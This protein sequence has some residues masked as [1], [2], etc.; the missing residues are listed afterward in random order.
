MVKNISVLSLLGDQTSPGD[1]TSQQAAIAEREQCYRAILETTTDMLG[2]LVYRPD[3]TLIDCNQVFLD[4]IGY[5]EDDLKQLNL[6]DIIPHKYGQCVTGDLQALQQKGRY[7]PYEEEY[8]DKHGRAV[9]VRLN[10]VWIQH[11]GGQD[12]IFAS[13]LDLSKY[14]EQQKLQS[15]LA[16]INQAVDNAFDAF[17][18]VN[19]R[20]EFIY[21]NKSHAKLWGY[22]SVD[23]VI[24][25]SPASHCADPRIAQHIIEQTIEQSYCDIEFEAR[26]K[27]GSLFCALMHATLGYDTEGREIYIASCIDI[28]ARKHTE[29]ELLKLKRAVE[30]SSTGIIITDKYGTI[31]YVNPKFTQITGY[32]SS[33]ALGTQ[34]SRLLSSKISH[35][36]AHSDMWDTITSGEDWSGVLRNSRK[37]GGLYWAK[38]AISSVKDSAGRVSHYIT[39][40]E[41]VSEYHELSEKLSYQASH[42]TLTGLIN[43]REFERRVQRVISA[44]RV[45]Q[46]QHGLCYMDLDQFKIVNDTCGH[47]AGDELLRQIGVVLKRTVRKRDTIAR[48]GGDEFAVLMEHCPLENARQVA[49]SLIEA[50]GEFQFNWKDHSFKLGISIGLVVIDGS[51]TKSMTQILSDA[52]MACYTAKDGGRNRV[53]VWHQK[54]ASIVERHDQMQWV[55]RIDKALDENRFCLYAQPILGLNNVRKHHELL[56]R[57]IDEQGNVVAPGAFLPA[58][59]RYN[60][61]VK[62]DRWIIQHAFSV[63]ARYPELTDTSN[64]FAIN[65]SAASLS[66][67]ATLEFIVKWLKQYRLRGD[68]ICFEITET[69][70]IANF[71]AAMDFINT[72]KSLGCRFALDDFGSGLSSFAY[73]KNLPVNYLKIDGM[74]VRDIA[75]DK[76]DFAMVKSINEVGQ[77]MD[78]KTIAEF[79]ENDSIKSKVTEIGI[80]YAQGYGIGKPIELLKLLES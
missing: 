24:G 54:D 13:V 66:E 47:I 46:T 65:L 34:L 36:K 79:V 31:E 60:L 38:N 73:L 71:K 59:E 40:H 69:A 16:L 74:F 57:M 15:R 35:G 23:E 27:D 8:T 2:M 5:D 76:V 9:P 39:I 41:D 14:S 75:D 56:V 64:F 68:S 33:E 19:N 51:N 50:V 7:G 1:Q 21:V 30:S 29:E 72:L 28:S 43:R 63:L 22:D 58:A 12:Y 67:A 25:L 37:D 17:S 18:I 62:L 32:A 77:V 20:G 45:P 52:D 53:H 10:E 11:S 42:D 6:A 80:D 49:K 48:L 61:S 3:G 70:A 4:I 26:R 44:T 78:M 55:S